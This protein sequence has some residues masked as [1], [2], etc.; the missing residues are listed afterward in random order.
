MWG[1]EGGEY[2]GDRLLGNVYQ[3]VRR[4]VP[5]T[6]NLYY[7]EY[8]VKSSLRCSLYNYY[9]IIIWLLERTA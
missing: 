9:E 2:E 8:V 6:Q 1:N 4:H 7:V 3:T 5:E